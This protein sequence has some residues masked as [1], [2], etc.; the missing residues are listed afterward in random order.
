[1][2]AAKKLKVL[3]N[4]TDAFHLV[5]ASHSSDMWYPYLWMLGREILVQKHSHPT[6]GTYWFPAYNGSEGVEVMK[7]IKSKFEAGISRQVQHFWGQ[8]FG[9]R[10][11]AV[12]LE[13]SWLPGALKINDSDNESFTQQVGMFPMSPV[14]DGMS[15]Q[16]ENKD[17][18]GS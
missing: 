3:L 7:F 14:P 18:T 8:E 15:S 17:L 13:G 9:D 12:M 6:K 1:L 4:G 10:K 2:N 5:G 16:T 11:F